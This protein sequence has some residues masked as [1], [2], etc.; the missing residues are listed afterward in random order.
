MIVIFRTFRF[1]FFCAFLSK[2]QANTAKISVYPESL[3]PLQPGQ[4]ARA[5]RAAQKIGG[6]AESP[7]PS[8]EHYFPR[9]DLNKHTAPKAMM[10]PVAGSGT[11]ATRN[12]KASPGYM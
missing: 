10:L 12:P 1:P 7:P 2:N 9:R 11:S 5:M 3:A 6:L 4:R 8:G